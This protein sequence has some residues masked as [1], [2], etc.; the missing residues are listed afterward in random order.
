MKKNYFFLLLALLMCLQLKAQVSNYVFSQSVGTYTPITGGTVVLSGSALDSNGIAVT[1]PTP[2]IFNGVS[3]TQVFAKVDGYLALGVGAFSST[4]PISNSTAA[5]G[6]IAALACDLMDA[7]ASGTVPEV[8]WE[9]IGD[10]IIFQWNDMARYTSSTS[11]EIFD[12]QIRLNTVNGTIN[13]VY[14][15]FS[16]VNATTTYTPQVGLRGA[17]NTDYNSRRLTTSVPDTSPSWDD[18][19]AA[20]SNG[21]NVRFTS[22]SPAAFPDNGRTF[23]WTAPTPCTGAPVAGTLNGTFQ[24]LC[25]GTTPSAIVTTGFSTGVTGLSFQWEESDDNGAADAWSNAVGGTGATTASY[26]PPSFAGSSIYYR[27]TV[28]CSNSS[29]SAS[30]SSFNLIPATSPSVEVTNVNTT[31]I[32]NTGFSLNWTNG[33]GNRRYVV[34]NNTNSF[35][36]PVNGTTGPATA[37][38]L[39]AGSGE[40]VVYDGTGSSVTVSGLTCNTTYYVRVYEYLRCGTTPTFDY[41]YNINGNTSN[42]S[43][44]TTTQPVSASLPASNDFTGFTGANLATVLPGWSEAA[45]ASSPSGSTSAWIS[46]TVFG[47]ATT[48]KINLYTTTRNEWIVSPRV[49]INADSRLKFKAAITDFGN[50]NIDAAGMQGTDDKVFV[51]VS[52]DGCG[53][54]WTPVYTFEA[55]NTNTLTNIL[56]D[57]I[58]S[59]NAYIGQTIQIAFKAQD[60]PVDDAPDYDFHIGSIVIENLPTCDLPT[61]LVVSNVLSTSATLSWNA[62]SIAPANGYEYYFDTVNTTPT[63]SGSATALTTADLA[64]LMPNTTYYVWVRSICATGN[65]SPWTAS[66]SFYTG[67]CIPVSTSS[68]TYIDNF[69]TT[70][71]SVDVSN[72]TSGYATSGYQNNFATLGVTEFV[73]GT[74]DVNASIVGGSLGLAVWVDWNN[75][76]TF[77]TSEVVYSTSSYGSGPY[78]FAITIPST[79]IPGDYVMRVM[80]DYNDSNPGDDS[81]CGF[82]GTRGE[83]EDYKLTVLAQPTDA[84]D[85]AN[86]QSFVANNSEVTSIESCQSVDVYTQGWEDGVTN[87]NATAPGAGIEVWIGKSGDDTDPATWSESL[88]TVATYNV[89]SG[90]NDE[91]VVNYSGLTLGTHYFASRWRLNNGPFRYGATNNGFWNGTTNTNAPLN[92]VAPVEITSSATNMI[93]CAGNPTTITAT[94]TNTNYEYVWDDAANTIGAVL[95]VSPTQTTT[96]VVTGT[97]VLTGCTNTSSITINV[98]TLPSTPTIA[99]SNNTVCSEEIVT[100]SASSSDTVSLFNEGFENGVPPTGWAS[101]IGTNGL[102][103]TYNWTTNTS[104]FSGSNAAFVRYE[105]VTGGNAEDWLVTP[106]IDLTNIT[107]PNLSFYTKQGFSSDFGSN[108]YVKVSTTSQTDMTTFT[109]AATWTEGTLNSAFSVYEMKN[110]DLSAYVGQQVYLAFVMTNDDGDNWFIDDVNVSA[111]AVNNV[112]WT[113][114]TNLYS[115][116]AATIAYVAN[117]PSNMVYY[118][119]NTNGAETITAMAVSNNLCES[120]DTTSITVN[121]TAAPTATAQTF[122]NSATVADLMATGTNL[123]WYDQMSGGTALISTATL[124]TGNYYVSQTLNSCES[125]RTLVSVTVNVTAAPTATAQTFCNSATVADLMATGTNLAWYDQMSGGT[126]LISTTTLATGNYYV[127]Q[128]LNSCESERTLVSVIVNVTAAPTA[129]AQTFCNS[130]TVADLMATGTNLTWYDQMSGGTALISTAT[131]ATGNYYVSQTLN[132]CESERTLVSVIVNVTAAPTGDALQNFNVAALSEATVADL[133]ATGSNIIWY[134]TAA[135][136]IAGSNPLA[137][138]VQLVNGETYYATQTVNSC[139]SLTSLEVTVTVTLGN[140]GFDLTKLKY[141]PNPVIDVVSISYSNVITTVEVF[142]LVGQKV[143]A[144]Q[145]NNNELNLNMSNLEAGAYIIQLQSEGLIESIKLI[146]K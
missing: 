1:L 84:V 108:Y 83:V 118:K 99:A 86:L 117:T 43:G 30:T 140:E 4:S 12:F 68:L 88:W 42:P 106:M 124:A 102:G 20:T 52:T 57:Y 27:L 59:L 39:Y 45:G 76:L 5:T 100:L 19:V 14:S 72:L 13:I 49:T 123:A 144:I 136:A 129:T 15:D 28:T 127:S 54:T 33:N 36:D 109:D 77:E 112:V 141:Y 40:Q 80:V 110:V 115:D 16:S 29:T 31:A 53:L 50:G 120:S 132:S 23:T 107:N 116:A 69:S 55:S 89:D 46:S 75:N 70:N 145:P 73:N 111:S 131:L 138:T 60:G 137:S 126:A 7:N 67:Y 143:M 96:Y 26:T 11:V 71:A 90:N 38:A 128:T 62:P 94:S 114:T 61:S 48:A 85:F 9:Q 146:K 51:M 93:T 135:D 134:A 21:H 58:V 35:T 78:N 125:E 64:S 87:A 105:N 63:V 79:T 22:T 133:M 24:I 119:S 32:T 122:C 47:S 91:F 44:F 3:V 92:V 121:V 17:T 130:A 95:T 18:T 82:G 81:A 104:S 101:F 74:F 8:R 139:T 97:N 56:T 65:E 142:N 2:F 34:V 103:S 25:T 66:A 113:P 10:E 41:Y 98:N 6:V 37:A